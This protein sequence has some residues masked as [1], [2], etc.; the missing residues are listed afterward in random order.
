MHVIVLLRGSQGF[1]A[2][3]GYYHLVILLL[4]KYQ[5]QYGRVNQ[6]INEKGQ[7]PL[8]TIAQEFWVKG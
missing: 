7:C 4:I 3:S 6:F 5:P 2:L 1:E 8:V